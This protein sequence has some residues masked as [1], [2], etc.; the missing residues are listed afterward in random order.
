MQFKISFLLLLL[1]ATS[2]AQNSFPESWIG[3]YKGDLK[4]YGV[5]S[6]KMNV[7]MYLDI[8]KTSKDSIFDWTI[9]YDMNGKKDVR[10]YNLVVIDREKGYFQ[11]DENNSILID[12]YLHNKNVF[13][14]FFKVMSSY[15]IA[16][17]TKN[18][19]GTLTFEIIA[20]K[21]D[22]V[23]TTGNTKQG[24][25]DIPEVNT[26]PVNGRQKAVLRKTDQD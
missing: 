12:A 4:I 18:K 8:V 19:D 7:K 21:A 11:I 10:A 20:G 13:T 6:V 3:N 22:S 5:D 15:I 17:Y 26:Y 1:C 16:T 24:E 23:S 9:T 14:S 2:F 25:E